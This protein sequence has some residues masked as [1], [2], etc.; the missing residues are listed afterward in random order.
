MEKLQHKSIQGTPFS[1]DISSI[2][3]K[4]GTWDSTKVSIY[5]D[6]I[7]IGEY[8]RNY[9]NYGFETF[10]PFQI[11]NDWYALYS[12]NYTATRVMKLHEDRIEDWCGEDAKSS[13]FCP[14][15]FYVPKYHQ[16]S[17]DDEFDIYYVD[18]D[19]EYEDLKREIQDWD[20]VKSEY[21]NFGFL[22]GCVWGD[23][24]SWKIR[25]IDLSKIPDKILSITEKFGYW[26]MPPDLTLKKC[27][28]MD[29]WEPGHDWI[30]LTRAEHI[31]LVTDERC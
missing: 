9:S 2:Q 13:G 6:N 23:D 7:L 11:D 17:Y 5:R 22:C 20:T 1:L 31:N 21:C 18:C 4:P 14:V 15:E 25:Y 27:I 26:E 24:T 29:G 8:I 10:Y 28:S 30:V 3:N 19:Y 12:A 16:S